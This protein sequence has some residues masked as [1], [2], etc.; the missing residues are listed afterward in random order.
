MTATDSRGWSALY[1]AVASGR[2]AIV[3]AVVSVIERALPPEEVRGFPSLGLVCGARSLWSDCGM[4]E[5]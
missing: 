5:Q 1:F 2:S 4:W 3:D